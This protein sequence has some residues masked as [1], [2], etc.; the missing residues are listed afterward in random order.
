ML[1]MWA[2]DWIAV[3]SRSDRAFPFVRGGGAATI[4]VR[5]RMIGPQ[6]GVP[7][8]GVLATTGYGWLGS[9]FVSF[10]VEI[11]HGV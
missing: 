2:A 7:A 8:D 9:V 10:F 4:R 5:H 11:V 1:L 3:H 6:A